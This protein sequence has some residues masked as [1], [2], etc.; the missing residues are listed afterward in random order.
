ME[1]RLYYVFDIIYFH[2]L[3][4]SRPHPAHTGFALFHLW[5]SIT[6]SCFVL[7]ILFRAFSHV[8]LVDTSVFKLSFTDMYEISTEVTHHDVY[9]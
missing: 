2:H 6:L 5:Y 9:V 3:P 4:Y 1:L 8:R 7:Q